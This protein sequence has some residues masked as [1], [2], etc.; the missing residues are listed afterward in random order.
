MNLSMYTAYAN[1]KV[2][3]SFSD[4]LR[5]FYGKGVRYGAFLDAELSQIPFH[6]YC[7]YLEDAGLQLDAFISTLDV[8]SFNEEKRKDN[9]SRLKE[10]ID[11]MEK[12]G[13]PILMIAPSVTAAKSE[14]DRLWMRE[15]MVESYS[16]AIDYAADSG[17]QVAV[18]NFSLLT[19]SDSRMEDLRYLFDCVPKLGFVIDSGNFFCIGEDVLAAYELLRDRIIHAHF[20]DW[21]WDPFGDVVRENMPRFTG[22]ALG[23]GVLPLRELAQ[24]L[25]QDK[26]E[27]NVVLEI[28]GKLTKQCLD[29]SV[30]FLT[31]VLMK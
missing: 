3:P 7:D 27:L 16:A 15:L 13:I 9:M 12:R 18:E 2:F 22:V 11:L 4:G 10:Q 23:Q 5:H 30:D 1:S 20:K 26:P 14:A 28:N 31:E 24:R 8:V 19:R 29:D 17:V 21:A 25:R 6:R